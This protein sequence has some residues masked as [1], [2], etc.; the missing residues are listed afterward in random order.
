MHSHYD[1]YKHCYLLTYF[2]V[3]YGNAPL[4]L[5]RVVVCLLTALRIH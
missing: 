3:D 5:F 1:M 2:T 4:R